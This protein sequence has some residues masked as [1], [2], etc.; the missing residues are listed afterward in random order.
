MKV[1]LFLIS[2][3]L[4]VPFFV[5]SQDGF[6][7]ENGKNKIVIPFKLVNNLIIISAN[8]NDVPLNFLL[9]TGV[10]ESIL[11][12][13][14]ET[15]QIIF[16]DLQKIKIKGFGKKEAFD[17]FKS[18]SN[19]FKL[20]NF[21]DRNHILYLILDQDVNISSKVGV[22]VNGILGYHFFKNHLVKIDYDAKKITLY[23]N[24]QKQLIKLEN[25]FTKSV[26]A[27]HDGKP[28][29]NTNIKISEK[30][31]LFEAK[32]LIDTGNSDA[33]WLFKNKSEK[34]TIPKN[35][36]RDYLGRGFSGD[37]F[38]YRGRISSF[39]IE[40]LLLKETIIAIPD[41]ND[42]KDVDEST[43]NRLGSIG[44]EIMKRYQVYFD[45]SSNALYLK[46]SN[47]Y[48]EPFNFNMSGIEVQHQGLQWVQESFENN[49]AMSNN[50]FDGNGNKV[51]NNLRY[52]FE[53]KP[54]YIITSVRE[55]SNAEE[56]GIKKDDIIV[57]INNNPAY[58]YSLQDINELLMS[59]EGKSI[60]IVV[61]RKGR[62]YTFKI[63]LKRII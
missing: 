30:D 20:K 43:I 28:Y 32:L 6:Q 59:E 7:F 18:T 37:V 4:Y 56:V 15:D 62:F 21:I 36:I 1:K 16:S 24:K 26:L 35:S 10:E 58:N 39:Q 31:S 12:S 63:K 13:L 40:N 57:K 27:V 49:P 8:I 19:K 23:K 3:F 9:D 51:A 2:C 11:F 61:D 48:N 17:G 60:E 52:K 5:F 47:T 34:V 53:L 44:G 38:G 54:V 55:N 42:T 33:V 50:L 25:N 41:S 45:Y 46:K 29:L 22:P 14:E